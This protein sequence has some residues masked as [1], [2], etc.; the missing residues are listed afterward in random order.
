MKYLCRKGNDVKVIA[1]K[2]EG[3][4]VSPWNKDIAG[5]TDKIVYVPGRYPQ[6]LEKYP[7]SLLEKIRYRLALLYVKRAI[8]GNYYDRGDLWKNDVISLA[9]KAIAE[10][11]N[12]I[13][14]TGAPFHTLFYLSSLKKKYDHLNFIADFRDPWVTN[15]TAYGFEGLAEERKRF[16]EEAE[17]TV[18]RTA[19]RIVTVAGDMTDYFAVISGNKE[20]CITVPNGFDPEDLPPL[21]D[22]VKTNHSKLRFVFT[23]TFYDKALHI[24]KAFC[25]GLDQ[26]KVEH[27]EAYNNMQFDFY[28]SMPAKFRELAK[29]HQPIIIHGRVSIDI[30]YK[31]IG[32]ADVCMLFLT[33][34]LNY[35]FSTKFYEYI[36]QRK[37]IAVFSRRGFTGEFVEQNGI[38]YSL[39]P[40]NISLRLFTLYRD[41]ISG[42]MKFNASFDI[43][44][45][46]VEQLTEK[47][48]S[49]LK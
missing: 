42:D 47:I 32:E 20:K 40:E 21:Q 27:P 41:F 39:E 18:A 31:V 22:P 15:R 2:Y 43:E 12:N 1:G 48:Q 25:S 3:Y 33:D 46:N 6:V 34:D 7:V 37:P 8:K 16:E 26:L 17:R 14:A 5:Y 30:V 49:L 23:G 19:D 44:A 13:I 4:E 9:E 24:F 10:G 29:G 35:S 45:Y 28:G 36:L 11:Y 38:G